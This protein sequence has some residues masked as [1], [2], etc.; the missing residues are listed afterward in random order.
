MVSRNRAF[1]T[2]RQETYSTEAEA[3]E[4]ID[5]DTDG[6]HLVVDLRATDDPHVDIDLRP[7]LTS[8]AGLIVASK[9]QLFVKRGV[10]IFASIF[11][12][13][14]LS[15]ILAL[16]A[17]AVALTSAGPTI[18]KQQRVGRDGRHFQFYKFRSM[19]ATAEDERE[20]LSDRNE[21]N[22]PVFKIFADPRITPIG[23][24]IRKTSIDELPQ[25]WNVLRGEMS[26]VG[27]RPPLPGEV[28]H[29]SAW[30]RQRLAVRPGVTGIWQ[31][32]GRADLDFETWV[33]MDIQYIEEWRPWLDFKLLAR[34]IPAVLSGRGAY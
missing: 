29:Y 23:K 9:F 8:D 3:I 11:F 34:T 17:L 31:V 22:G 14:V 32:S 13:A 26:L 27:P 20:A 2:E 1:S 24:F 28:E 33:T 4:A 18:F 15:P 7:F 5:L 19:S 10:D 16:T 12:L 6:L 30:E 25:F 21:S